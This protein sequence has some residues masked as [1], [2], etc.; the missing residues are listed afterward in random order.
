MSTTG[1]DAEVVHAWPE[2]AQHGLQGG[3][4]GR[5]CGCADHFASCGHVS[6]ENR[7]FEG[8][9]RPRPRLESTRQLVRIGLVDDVAYGQPGSQPPDPCHP[10]DVDPRS[11]RTCFRRTT[12]C[13]SPSLLTRRDGA[14]SWGTLL[15]PAHGLNLRRW[16]FS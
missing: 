6:D 13:A 12:R 5:A 10:L 3:I 15:A 1:L 8:A 2:V 11:L 4:I 9:P 7:A 14:Q 16:T